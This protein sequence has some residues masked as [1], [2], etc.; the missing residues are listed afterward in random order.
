VM[1]AAAKATIYLVHV[2]P[3]DHH[4]YEWDGWGKAYKQDSLEALQMT[5]GLMRP[6]DGTVLQTVL[7][8]GDIAAELL[9]FADSVRADLIATGSNGH[10]FVAR[11]LIGSVATRVLRAATCSVLTVP[12]AAAMTDARITALPP[13]GETIPRD[14]WGVGL[15]RFSQ[16]NAGRRALLEIDDA[17]I[18]A[19]AQEF[20]YPFRGA[21]FDHNDGRITLMFGADGDPGHHLT[22]GIASPSSVD[23][24]RDRA[25]S[26]IALRIAHGKGQTLMTFAG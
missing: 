4:R 6:A 23:L 19:Q 3:R 14:D 9:Q 15:A 25:G 8:Q 17:D 26:D 16:R 7:L 12:H 20:D 10:G 13:L 21:T 11:M 2:A 24:L 22:R 18:G 1:L 5:K